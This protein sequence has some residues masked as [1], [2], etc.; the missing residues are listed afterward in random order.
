MN[1][2]TT[3]PA[4]DN[5]DRIFITDAKSD[6]RLN[7]S[8]TVYIT[9]QRPRSAVFNWFVPVESP[10]ILLGFGPV[11]GVVAK[12]GQTGPWQKPG[13]RRT[14][15]LKDG[16]T[17]REEVTACENPRYFAYR[18]SGFTNVFRSFTDEAEGQWWF[19]EAGDSTEV[20]W[21]STFHARSALTRSLLIPMVKLLWNGYMRVGIQVVKK[22]AER[23][24]L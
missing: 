17:A 6:G 1:K 22:R 13:S 21:R 11:P 9:V 12:S 7:V 4:L 3:A 19:E 24:A 10:G 2:G 8:S 23:E 16:T 20:K 5:S 14:V 15:H 18:V